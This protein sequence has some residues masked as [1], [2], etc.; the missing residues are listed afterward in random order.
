[1]SEFAAKQVIGWM[2][3]AATELSISSA[4]YPCTVTKITAYEREQ[5]AV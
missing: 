4:P 1:M 2:K 3:P 5:G